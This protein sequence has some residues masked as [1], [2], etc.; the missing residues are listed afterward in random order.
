[1]GKS[2]VN[3]RSRLLAK[4]P[5]KAYFLWSL[6]LLWIVFLIFWIIRRTNRIPTASKRNESILKVKEIENEQ[7]KDE[8]LKS[9]HKK[10]DFK[11]EKTLESLQSNRVIIDS[12]RRS[13]LKGREEI[14]SFLDSLR[15]RNQDK[16]ALTF[17][18]PELTYESH[19]SYGNG[20]YKYNPI[21]F[22][23]DEAQFLFKWKKAYGW[24][25][26]NHI[27]MDLNLAN[28]RPPGVRKGHH[29][30][31]EIRTSSTESSTE[32]EERVWK[33]VAVLY[34]HRRPEYLR[35][36]LRAFGRNKGVEDWLLI[37]RY[38]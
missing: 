38:N 6:S 2:V 8:I 37:I 25:P 31:S 30:G 15:A 20:T 7:K 24:P 28:R 23:P 36:I 3:M 9:L 16:G 14:L 34:V 26:K 33:H 18:L 4:R 17:E 22:T 5:R 1:M 32:I 21:P 10:D 29:T 12:L 19:P 13:K 11:P 35:S 27:S